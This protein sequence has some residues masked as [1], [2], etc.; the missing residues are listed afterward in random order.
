MV[1]VVG[2]DRALASTVFAMNTNASPDP[3]ISVPG[4][5]QLDSASGRRLETSPTVSDHAVL[6]IVVANDWSFSTCL[7]PPIVHRRPMP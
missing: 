4:P 3:P 2:V 1:P 5:K 6:A 7:W